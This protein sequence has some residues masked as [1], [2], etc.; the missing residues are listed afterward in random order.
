[1]KKLFVLFL[2]LAAVAGLMFAGDIHPPGIPALALPGYGVD[3]AAVIPDT[4]LVMET[5]EFPD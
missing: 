2:C 3:Y 1:M 5:L 4:V